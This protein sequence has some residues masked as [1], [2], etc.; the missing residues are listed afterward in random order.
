M[1]I[2]SI[3]NE[4]SNNFNKTLTNNLN[5]LTL[6]SKIR[7]CGNL[8]TTK[9]YKTFLNYFDKQFKKNNERKLKYKIKQTRQRTLI[10]SIGIITFNYT[11]YID[12]KN[13]DYFVKYTCSEKDGGTEFEYFEWAENGDLDA[14]MEMSALELLKEQIE[15][16]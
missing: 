1:N 5:Q 7:E 15:N 4:I 11:S 10:T 13:G 6:E 8:F 16:M 9:L 12:K 2:V 3:F 14:L